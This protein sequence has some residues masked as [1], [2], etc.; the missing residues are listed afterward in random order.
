MRPEAMNAHRNAEQTHCSVHKDAFEQQ[1]ERIL[2]VP[3]EPQGEERSDVIE[4]R[5][6]STPSDVCYKEADL[7]QKRV[8]HR[9]GHART[10]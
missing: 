6:I 2:S 7:P 3:E 9:H 4:E 5:E 1:A 8:F 10:V